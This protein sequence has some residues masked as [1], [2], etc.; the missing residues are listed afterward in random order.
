MTQ[1]LVT[2]A[3]GFIGTHLVRALVRQGDK[4]SCLIRPTSRT[5]QLK[6]YGVR[7]ISADVTQ[8]DG[9]ANAV[10]GHDIVYHL[11]GCNNAIQGV[12]YFRVNHSGAR[13]MAQACAEQ[14]S[15]PVM[16]LMSSL[17]AAG[18]APD[19]RPRTEADP[20]RPV[21]HYGRSKLAGERAAA[22]YADRV[23]ITVLRP[24]IVFGQGDWQV[25]NIFKTVDQLGVHFVPAL[26]R[27]RHS[28]IH[29]ADLADAAI[30]AAAGAKRL[31][32]PSERGALTQATTP[33]GAES[34]TSGVYY[35]GHNEHF[36]YAELGHRIGGALDRTRVLVCPTPPRAIWV[37]AAVNEVASR[38]T[39]RPALLNI[40]KAREGRA[41]CWT[42]NPQRAADEFGY[43][44]TA[45]LDDR[46]RETARWY[47]EQGWL[48]RR[49]PCGS[50][51]SWYPDMVDRLSHTNHH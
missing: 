51:T 29:A 36:T 13:N 8:P 23:P 4:V 22:E 18:P 40:D 44:V 42:C 20:E 17:A 6:P 12:E 35:V 41:G 19:G 39:R 30:A 33:S 3:T 2:G 45:S 5:E 7:L 43:R 24:P 38:V 9:L 21:S 16:V 27:Q 37:V 31:A 50:T 34:A 46:L 28:L 25:F 26:G 48:K 15:P 11:A 47:H 10:A 1:V 32:V 14:A 49:E